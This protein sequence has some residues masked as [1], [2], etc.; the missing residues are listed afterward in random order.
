MQVPVP[1]Q[2]TPVQPVKTD[3]FVGVAVNVTVVLLA[4]DETQAVPQLIPEGV[5]VAMPVPD[6]IAA[7]VSVW[8]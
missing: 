1:V 4:Y 6:P 2:P 3:P 7:T 5:E 8:L